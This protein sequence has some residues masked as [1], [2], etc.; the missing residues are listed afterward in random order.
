[1]EQKVY[2]LGVASRWLNPLP[3]E[4]TYR[5]RHLGVTK[6]LFHSSHLGFA[7]EYL[8]R[9]KSQ[10]LI[11]SREGMLLT[12]RFGKKVCWTALLRIVQEYFL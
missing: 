5:Q 12:S 4:D 11:M 10:M 8:P 3:R 2:N 1:M 9:K 7:L 6:L